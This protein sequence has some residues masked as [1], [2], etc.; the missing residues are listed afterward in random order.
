MQIRPFFT[1][2]LAIIS[3]LIFDEKSR[4]GAII[5]PTPLLDNYIRCIK[6]ENIQITHILETHVHADFA[7]GSKELKN[8]LQDSPLIVCSGLGGKEWCPTYAD[9]LIKDREEIKLGS[10]RLQAWHTPGHTP[11]HIMWV[12]FDDS[13]NSTTPALAFT[14]DLLFVGS[15]GRPDL[16]GDNMEKILTKELYQTLF[17]RISSLPDHLEILPAHGTGSLCGKE[18]GSRLSSTLGYERLCNPW[19]IKQPF[20]KW[21]TALLKNMP[22]APSYFKRMKRINVTGLQTAP[23]KETPPILDIS[24]ILELMPSSF[25]IDIRSP[26]AFALDHLKG[27]VNIP[28]APSFTSWAGSVVPENKNIL[29]V[30]GDIHEAMFVIQSLMLIGINSIKGICDS[31][32]WHRGHWNEILH[33]SP[34]AIATDIA[35]KKDQFFILDV[36]TEG[37]WQSGHIQEAHH[38]ELSQVPNAV[39]RIPNNTPIAVFCHSGGR[40]SVIASWLNQQGYSQAI[41][42]KGGMQAWIQAGLPTTSRGDA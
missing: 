12:A 29:V 24:Q 33:P 28:L 39:N 27:A 4:K 22:P 34:M 20:E 30:V 32:E 3:Y 21:S 23:P 9:I 16:L 35:A 15:I 40:A 14:G 36:R 18:I 1:P 19:L 26:D 5:D 25:I 11:E 7:S 17:E 6:Q 37:E 13:R 31:R 38:I 10:I 8:F 41:S 2:G 42:V